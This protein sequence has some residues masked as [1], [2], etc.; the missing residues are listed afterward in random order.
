MANDEVTEKRVGDAPPVASFKGAY[1]P[2]HAYSTGDTVTY[3][4]AM[5]TATAGSTGVAPTQAANPSA[6][7]PVP[8]GSTKW[9]T[10]QNPEY[11]DMTPEVYSRRFRPSIWYLTDHR[12]V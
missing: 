6:T 4:G 1:D 9:T 5:Y 7:P 10:D 3:Q 12:A 2:A 8:A 11:W